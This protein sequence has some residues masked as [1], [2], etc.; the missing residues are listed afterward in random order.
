[1]EG[2]FEI[3]VVPSQT[4][5]TARIN[6]SNIMESG[7]GKASTSLP[8]EEGFNLIA[9]FLNLKYKSESGVSFK[10]EAAT[11]D[12]RIKAFIEVVYNIQ[13]R[14]WTEAASSTGI[15]LLD[16]HGPGAVGDVA[17]KTLFNLV[18]K[19]VK[20][21]II[22]SLNHELGLFASRMESELIFKGILK[23]GGIAID[24]ETPIQKSEYIKTLT[25]ITPEQYEGFAAMQKFAMKR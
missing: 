24:M 10:Q 9:Y 14:Q 7:S 12:L 23:L 13:S 16:F 1:M 18:F 25:H 20:K 22:S 19:N 3:A 5:V 8:S 4:G 17:F 21:V 6:L 2:Q 15:E 11:Y